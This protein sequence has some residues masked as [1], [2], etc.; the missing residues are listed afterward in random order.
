[1]QNEPPKR[2]AL[3]AALG[4]IAGA[5]VLAAYF[6]RLGKIQ[7][8]STVSFPTVEIKTGTLDV[9]LGILVVVF[10]VGTVALVRR[11]GAGGAAV[12]ELIVSAVA[13][14]LGLYLVVSNDA[15]IRRAATTLH[16]TTD[17]LKGGVARG[18]VSISRGAGSYLVLIGG[19][20]G[21]IAAL[22][23]LAATRKLP[24]AIPAPPPP[25]SG[26]SFEG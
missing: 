15:F 11:G 3:P 12:A 4:V 23:T 13:L 7:P 16:L 5:V 22:A 26:P 20:L 9:V 14:A 8:A 18:F 24:S 21:V 19:A 2:P 6:L 10:A 1:V 25:G 17:Q